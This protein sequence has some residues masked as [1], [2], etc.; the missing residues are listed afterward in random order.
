M[1]GNNKK[2]SQDLSLSNLSNLLTSNVTIDVSSDSECKV[3]ENEKCEQARCE[4]KLCGDSILEYDETKGYYNIK[5]PGWIKINLNEPKEISYLRFLLWDNR[6]TLKKRQPS[7]RKYIY[8]LLIEEEKEL[9]QEDANDRI[10]WYQRILKLCENGISWCVSLFCRK[11]VGYEHSGSNKSE[12]KKEKI[13]WTAIYE[14][15]LNP[16]NGWQEFYFENG[17]KKIKSI[18]I[19]FF[20]NT[21]ASSSHKN[22]TQLVSVQAYSQPTYAIRKLLNSDTVDVNSEV[23]PLPNLGF[24]R[25]R[26]IFGGSEEIMNNIVENE[27]I[28]KVTTYINGIENRSSVLDSL[29]RDLE[30]GNKSGVKNDIEKQIHIF[31]QSILKPINAYDKILS[32][33]FIGYTIVAIALSIIGIVKEV[34]DICYLTNG[35]ANPL[36][37]S[38]WLDLFL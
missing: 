30:A 37:I 29:L 19:Q 18:K 2:D 9:N 8:R 35:K 23:A 34:L 28:T 10:K 36:T 20:Q 13:V 15:T 22:Y 12:T 26:V 6:G 1:K 7:N 38:Y 14:N 25:N 16:A 31:N 4:Y 21:S 27:I 33:R 17:A 5:N 11:N 3:C 32:R 24:V